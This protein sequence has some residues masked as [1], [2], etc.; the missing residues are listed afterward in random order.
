[1][2]ASGSKPIVKLS[3]DE[4]ITNIAAILPRHN[5]QMILSQAW[6]FIVLIKTMISN[7]ISIGLLG[8]FVYIPITFC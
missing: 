2:C 8:F 5:N 7:Q 4:R 1:M 3:F 6:G